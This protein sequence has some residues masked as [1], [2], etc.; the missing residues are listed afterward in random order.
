MPFVSI[1]QLVRPLDGGPKRLMPRLCIPAGAKK[2]QPAAETLEHLVD[3]EQRRPGC[4]ELNRQWKVVEAS[5]ELVEALIRLEVGPDR[6]SARLEQLK[7]VFSRE[8]RN[9]V[10]MFALQRQPLAA[11]H[12]HH[13]VS[14]VSKE[15]RDFR[16]RRNDVFEVVQQKQDAAA[17]N[18]LSSTNTR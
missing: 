7:R 14:T 12:E 5:A 1:Q 9:W 13:E 17:S 6:M 15:L 8:H 11:R 2:I 16:C 4:G 10:D 3:G 18:R